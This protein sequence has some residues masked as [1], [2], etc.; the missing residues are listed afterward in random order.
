LPLLAIAAIVRDEA[1]A[2]LFSGSRRDASNTTG[3]QPG[4]VSNRAT[5][6]WL[7]L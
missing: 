4:A 1:L 5:R 3:P 6:S 7:H 2:T